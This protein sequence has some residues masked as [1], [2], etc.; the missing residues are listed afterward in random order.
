LDVANKAAPAF[1]RLI[2]EV[3]IERVEEEGEKAEKENN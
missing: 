2:A 1:R 3:F